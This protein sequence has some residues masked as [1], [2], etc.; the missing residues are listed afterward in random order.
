MSN[1]NVYG[2][3]PFNVVVIHGGPGA[4]GE[5]APVA[6][7]LSKKFGVIEPYQTSFSFQGQVV[8]LFEQIKKY[9]TPPVKLVGYSYGAWL[10]YIF[11][12]KYQETVQKII[13][14]CSGSFDEKHNINILYERLSRLTHNEAEEVRKLLEIISD[15]SNKNI[16]EGFKRFGELISLADTHE[17]ITGLEKTEII[18]R[19]DIHHSVWNDAK[20]M[21]RTGALLN[22]AYDIKCPVTA[23]HGDYDPHPVNGV[24]EPLKEIIKNFKMIVLKKCGH[25]PW[26][27]KHARE[28]FFEV[29]EKELL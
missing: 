10:A 20:E 26:R 2:E 17:E 19:P 28:K 5:V 27:E 7:K 14:V 8:E 12:A 6:I 1:V 23:I 15:I 11:A 3:E 21:R 29:L 18:F 9:C 24:K 16:D 22:F 13:L 25:T 4:A